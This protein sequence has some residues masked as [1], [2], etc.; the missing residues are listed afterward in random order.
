MRRPQKGG[1]LGPISRI[2]FDAAPFLDDIGGRLVFSP[3]QDVLMAHLSHP[4]LQHA[5]SILTRRRFPGTGEEVSRWTVRLSPLPTGTDALVLLSVE[6]LAVND[7]RETFHHWVRT[8]V[9][10]ISRGRLGAPLPHSSALA[11]RG[12][13]MTLEKT[14]HDAARA[15]V[16]DIESDIKTALTRHSDQLTKSLLAQLE[17]SG[18]ASRA[19]EEHR[20]RSRQAE[21]STL[22]S[23]TTI[24]KLEREI[25]TLKG[26]RRQG[27]LFDEANRLDDI[28]RSIEEKN[29]EI[30]RRTKHYK[31]VRDQLERER[32]RVLKFLLPK[33]HAMS[34][35]AQVFPVCIEVRLPGGAR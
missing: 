17:E 23:E 27:T 16:E 21:V 29:A 19:D 31:E 34:G 8:I 13:Q 33:R 32:E 12:A 11:L 35:P 9:F 20:Y 3:R 4:M 1:S 26:E 25:E 2:A 14:H 24:A 7:L 18:K 15:I 5:I 22:I 6:E 30:D 10:P 28:D